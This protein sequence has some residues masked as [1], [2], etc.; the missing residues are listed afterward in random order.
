MHGTCYGVLVPGTRMLAHVNACARNW[1]CMQ[2]EPLQM[3][4]CVCVCV[5]HVNVCVRVSV[6]VH[7]T[8]LLSWE[9]STQYTF[10]VIQTAGTACYVGLA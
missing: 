3:C 7:C 9:P 1:M 4:V 5:L 2:Q 6:C 10:C 8:F